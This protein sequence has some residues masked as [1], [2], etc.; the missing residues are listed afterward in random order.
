MSRLDEACIF[1]FSNLFTSRLNSLGVANLPTALASLHEARRR[2]KGKGWLKTYVSAVFHSL[3]VYSGFSGQ[4]I[5]L[6]KVNAIINISGGVVASIQ[7]RKKAESLSE[8]D[9]KS[10][11]FQSKG[12]NIS[13]L[14]KTLQC[15]L[16]STKTKETDDISDGKSNYSLKKGQGFVGRPARLCP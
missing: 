10:Q 14:F 1:L 15:K 3:V 13:N 11:E 6:I 12:R 7:A 9:L 2:E 16:F 4:W 5:D 8:A